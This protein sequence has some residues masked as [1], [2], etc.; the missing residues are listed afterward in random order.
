MTESLV[1]AFARMGLGPRRDVL[2]RRFAP[3]SL[4]FHGK[5]P[6]PEAVSLVLAFART[7]LGPRRDAAPLLLALW[8]SEDGVE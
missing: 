6:Q 8:G 3:S 1:L 5:T 7:G 2:P 4:R